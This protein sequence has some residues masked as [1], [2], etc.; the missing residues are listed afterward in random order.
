MAFKT[1]FFFGNIQFVNI[2]N[3]L[4]FKAV[5]IHIYSAYRLFQEMIEAFPDKRNTIR[6]LF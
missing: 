6:F 4:L 5:I 3:Q 2:I 1:N